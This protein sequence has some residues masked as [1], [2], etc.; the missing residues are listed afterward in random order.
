[1]TDRELAVLVMRLDGATY[2]AIGEVFGFS[3]ER[4]RQIEKRADEKLKRRRRELDRRERLQTIHNP[5]P[6][7]SCH[8]DFEPQDW[9]PEMQAAEFARHA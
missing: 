9:T 7:A 2:D 5:E 8:P 1:M 6:R 4:G 3:R